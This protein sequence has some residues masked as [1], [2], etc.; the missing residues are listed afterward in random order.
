MP[1]KAAV[2]VPVVV[3]QEN[4]PETAA[5]ELAALKQALQATKKE[6]ADAKYLADIREKEVMAL[7]KDLRARDL[8]LD[9]EVERTQVA[10]EKLHLRNAQV[11]RLERDLASVS[12]ELE[13]REVLIGE[14][15][16]K[17]RQALT[18]DLARLVASMGASGA[19]GG[20]RQKE[21]ISLLT[22]V[23]SYGFQK[24]K[25]ILMFISWTAGARTRTRSQRRPST[26]GSFHGSAI[27][28][29]GKA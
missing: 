20:A 11:Q 28:R 29:S 10:E 23:I 21:V 6:L 8:A 25:S 13:T 5:V 24:K 1:A 17:E 22:K 16:A 2:L 26:A 19:S 4:P 7:Q 27:G 9:R 12:K 14:L 18:S 15:R 3:A